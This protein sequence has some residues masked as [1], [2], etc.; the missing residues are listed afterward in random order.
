MLSRP[1]PLVLAALATGCGALRSPSL[2][3]KVH[4]RGEHY[5]VIHEPVDRLWPQV[6]RGLEAEGLRVARAERAH[7]TIQT[8][9]RRYTSRDEVRKLGDIADLSAA[10][11]AGLARATE[12]VVT[13]TLFLLPAG[14]ADT[15]LKITSTIEAID[16]S[17]ALFLGPGVFD[18]IPRHIEVPSRG[19]VERD[20]LRRLAAS[21]FTAEEMLFVFGEP[22]FD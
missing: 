15:S 1:L 11:A 16:R 13:Y 17:E 10:R 14:E 20:F 18:V 21:L 4:V 2:D 12:Y 3:P 9:G 6:L 8:A 7:R 19:V 5:R 22:G